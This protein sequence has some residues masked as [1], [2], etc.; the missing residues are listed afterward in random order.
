[1]Q[2]LLGQ[3]QSQ[4]VAAVTGNKRGRKRKIPLLEITNEENAV[5]RASGALEMSLRRQ[6][7][8]QETQETSLM[9][10]PLSAPHFHSSV[11]AGI[12]DNGPGIPEVPTTPTV[13]PDV[14]IF[15]SV[16]MPPDN[17]EHSSLSHGGLTQ[18]SLSHSNLSHGMTPL[19]L[20]G[21]TPLGPHGDY[22]LAGMTPHHHGIDQ[23]ESIPNLPA[24]QV[25]S[26]LN[27]AGMDAFANMGYDDGQGASAG[28]SERIANDWNDD[29]DFPQ[30]MGAHVSYNHNY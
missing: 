22:P 11:N 24:D 16:G 4:D 9:G 29:Y 7:E 6:E 23:L 19:T 13:D 30:S 21:M 3:V 15:G 18:G 8:V 12:P 2:P 1:M 5:P 27:G 25:S 14:S 20:C 28:M 26:I 17:L 10:P